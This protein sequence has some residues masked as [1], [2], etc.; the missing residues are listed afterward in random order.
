MRPSSAEIADLFQVS[1]GEQE[2]G[3]ALVH[4]HAA[5]DLGDQQA[6]VVIHAEMRPHIARRS[7]E[8]R[9]AGQDERYQGV[10]QIH[11]RRQRVEGR[12]GQ[13]ALA[14]ETGGG[15]GLAGQAANEIH[16]QLRQFLVMDRAVHRQRRQAG[17]GIRR[18]V[19]SSRQHRVDGKINRPVR[20]NSARQAS[21]DLSQVEVSR[22]RQI[23]PPLQIARVGRARSVDH[24]RVSRRNHM[25]RRGPLGEA[26]PEAASSARSIDRTR[27][28]APRWPAPRRW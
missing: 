23:G 8:A 14:A 2:F 12:L 20:G 26:L 10:V 17:L 28:R 21:G 5:P 6:D 27:P 24:A 22:I 9:I 15:R 11:H 1:V 13:R 16:E 19:S 18:A 3:V 25:V 7:G 4:A